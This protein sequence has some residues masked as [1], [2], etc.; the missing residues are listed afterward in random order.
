MKIKMIHKLKIN[1]IT[2][3]KGQVLYDPED[4]LIFIWDAMCHNIN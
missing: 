4:N 2:T 1:L 3:K